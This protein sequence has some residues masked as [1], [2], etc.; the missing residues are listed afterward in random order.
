MHTATSTSRVGS[1]AISPGVLAKKTRTPE[2]LVDLPYRVS[3]DC[4]WVCSSTPVDAIV[5]LAVA[6]KYSE[7]EGRR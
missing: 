7:S 2:N 5:V 3:I 6:G 1:I 4:S